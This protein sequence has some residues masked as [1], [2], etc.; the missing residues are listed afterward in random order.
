MED[1]KQEQTLAHY[2]PCVGASRLGG[3]NHISDV[4]QLG[5]FL[6]Q[7]NLTR[8][9][10]VYEQ[11]QAGRF[12]IGVTKLVFPAPFFRILALYGRQYQGAF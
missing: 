7:L 3:Q 9:V 6:G 4:L 12:V 8:R 10:L 5:N 1:D 2:C 11:L